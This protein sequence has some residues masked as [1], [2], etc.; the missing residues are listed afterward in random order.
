MSLL[1]EGQHEP[2][3][4]MQDDQEVK[5][6]ASAPFQLQLEVIPMRTVTVLMPSSQRLLSPTLSQRYGSLLHPPML[7]P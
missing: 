6:I 7:K 5:A 4:D 3:L 1:K 2:D